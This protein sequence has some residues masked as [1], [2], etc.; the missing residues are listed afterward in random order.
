MIAKKDKLK[1]DDRIFMLRVI[2]GEKPLSSIGMVD[3]TLFTGGNTLHARYNVQ[4]GWWDCYYDHG[5]V[6]EP[7]AGTW[8]SY[9]KLLFDVEAYL[10]K[11]N[12]EIYQV[13]D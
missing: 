3:K 8:T 13:L 4:S 9:D 6:P 5:R 7:L 1:K 12:I 11:R 10:R 2:D